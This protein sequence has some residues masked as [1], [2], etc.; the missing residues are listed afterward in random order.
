MSEHQYGA[1]VI[2]YRSDQST[3]ER[4]GDARHVAD[5]LGTGVGI[6]VAGE[7]EC[8]F[9]S[10]IEHGA[11]L[12]VHARVE[13]G[14]CLTRVAAA[15]RI[16]R[17][18][19]PR[20]VFAPGDCRG[21]EWAARL[22]VRCSWKLVSPALMVRVDS[23]GQLEVTGL[24]ST[25]RLSRNIR[26]DP[27]ETVVVTLRV[28]VAEALPA[29][30]KRDGRVE[31]V[32]VGHVDEPVTLEESLPADPETVDI[33][34]ANRLVAG[35]RGLGG[36]EGFEK[37]QSFAKKIGAG[38]AASRMAVD[39][40]WIEYERQVGQTGKSVKPDLY[41]ACGISGASHHLAGVSGVEHI[42]AINTDLD[43]PIFKAA[44]LG[45]VADLYEVLEQAGQAMDEQR[46]GSQ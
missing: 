4:L 45:L 42:V 39:L 13:N 20:L 19:A 30:S 27:D 22:V 36:K 1:W 32:E 8:D 21:R 14:G 31:T 37:L 40:G 11:D 41:I 3:L 18:H 5:R 43:A 35:G 12:V 23:A 26:S 34:Y 25:G 2:D 7:E 10:L 29:D 24:D 15:E 6:V 16:L 44:H 17:S 46:A 33:R 38:V 28:G 9:R